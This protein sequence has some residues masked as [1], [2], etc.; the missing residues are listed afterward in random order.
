VSE[1]RETNAGIMMRCGEGDKE[2]R[3]S[4]R[5]W[6]EKEGGDREREKIHFGNKAM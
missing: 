4:R 6:R 1:E 2:G 5:R 3:S